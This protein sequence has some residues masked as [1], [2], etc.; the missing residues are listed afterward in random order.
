MVLSRG[1]EETWS[2]PQGTDRDTA[3]SPTPRVGWWCGG[4]RHGLPEESQDHTWHRKV[5]PV[6]ATGA[7]CELTVHTVRHSA[8]LRHGLAEESQDHTWR[9]KVPVSATGAQCELAVKCQV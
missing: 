7:Q 1:R 5:A 4:P 3:R 6:S 8:R 9:W 2:T